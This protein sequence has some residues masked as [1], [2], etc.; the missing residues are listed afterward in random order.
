MTVDGL[1]L[2]ARPAPPWPGSPMTVD[3]NAATQ[4]FPSPRPAHGRP[5]PARYLVPALAAAAVAIALGVYGKVHDPAA[6]AFDLAG[7]SSTGSVK[8]WLATAAFLFALVQVVSALIVYGR[9]PARAGPVRCTAGRAA[10][11]SWPRSRSRSTA[12]TR[13]AIRRTNRAFCGTPSWVVSYSVRSVPRC[14]CSVRS[15]FPPGCCRSSAVS[16]SPLS[17]SSG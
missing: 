14:C 15:D 3:P 1:R 4:G 6:T 5:H 7:F 13:W 17:R 11:P 12:C 9:L 8:S 10:P 16:S 2:T